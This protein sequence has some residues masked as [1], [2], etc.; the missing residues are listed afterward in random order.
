M[1]KGYSPQ[2]A[3]SVFLF[4]QIDTSAID[5]SVIK[6]GIQ[7]TAFISRTDSIRKP[8]K[9]ITDSTVA[10][11]S[12]IEEASLKIQF[13]PVSVQTDY[14]Y[15]KIQEW[16]FNDNFLLENPLADIKFHEHHDSLQT[17]MHY[18]NE[19]SSVTRKVRQNDLKNKN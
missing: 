11:T 4:Q 12:A 19:I 16:D 18:K 9:F 3:D 2:V 5:S 10:D 7:D 6:A 1:Q 8:V 14:P 13:K 15:A 17:T